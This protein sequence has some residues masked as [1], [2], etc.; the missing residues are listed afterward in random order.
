MQQKFPKIKGAVRPEQLG[1]SHG[2]ISIQNA[3]VRAILPSVP[4]YKREPQWKP[5]LK[6]SI[7]S[8]A[9]SGDRK[10]LQ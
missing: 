5:N 1:A 10:H 7:P 6:L 2:T 8:A 9:L 3:H 4:T